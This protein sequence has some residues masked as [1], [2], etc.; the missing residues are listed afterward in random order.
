[1]ENLKLC[2]WL[3]VFLLICFA[4]VQ[5]LSH[6]RLFVTMGCSMPGSLFFTISQSLLK[7]M[8]IESV[9]LSNHHILCHPLLLLPSVFP[10]I[11]INTAKNIQSKENW[12]RNKGGWHDII[13][14]T[15][16]WMKAWILFLVLSD[17]ECGWFSY[18][19]LNISGPEFFFL[20]SPPSKL[21]YHRHITY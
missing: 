20:S 6:V 4:F 12:N 10:N 3:V 16:T 5:L 1:M 19:S 13:E 14:R 21:R 2:T 9:M 8:S 15:L 7:F 17:S 11:R 18:L